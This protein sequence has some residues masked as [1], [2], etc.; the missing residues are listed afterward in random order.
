MSSAL[1]MV[2]MAAMVVPA[3]RPEKVSGEVEQRLDLRGEWEGTRYDAN[4]DEWVIE[5]NFAEWGIVDEGAGRLR[6]KYDISSGYGIYQQH[7]DRLTISISAAET[8]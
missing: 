3:N 2:L 8:G 1:A 6:F 4:G 7:G 5:I